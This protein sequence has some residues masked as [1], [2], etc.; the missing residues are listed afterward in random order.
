MK[1]PYKIAVLCDLRD[2][3]GRILLIHRAKSPNRGLCSPIGGKLET[4]IGESPT[5]CAAREI[6]E[7]AGVRIPLDRLRLKGIVSEKG[8]EGE[9]H[10][11]IFIYRALD[12]VIVPDG[13]IMEGE[14]RWHELS[15]LDSLPMPD[16]D[17]KV[18]WPLIFEHTHGVFVVHIDCSVEP[19][20]WSIEAS[21]NPPRSIT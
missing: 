19:M 10:W 7:E 5:Q 9:S 12:P 6:F 21:A 3:D 4:A 20:R 17:R 14:L 15:E 8:Y 16:T 18:L 1:L 2:A 13:S 11:L